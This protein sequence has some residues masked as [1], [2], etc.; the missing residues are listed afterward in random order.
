MT[1]Q[2]MMEVFCVL[3]WYFSRWRERFMWILKLEIS[4]DE[5]QIG[6]YI[7]AGIRIHNK[8]K[9]FTPYCPMQYFLSL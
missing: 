9:S 4:D 2:S 3:L 8:N 6:R 5:V 7:M 1:L